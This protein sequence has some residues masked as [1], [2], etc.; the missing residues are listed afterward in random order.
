MKFILCIFILIFSAST[1]Y[2]G[3][4]K[5][6]KRI[7]GKTVVFK[8]DEISVES[9]ENLVA[10]EILNKTETEDLDIPS[11]GKIAKRVK[12]RE[13]IFSGVAVIEPDEIEKTIIPDKQTEESVKKNIDKIIIDKKNDVQDEKNDIKEL[14]KAVEEEKESEDIA[15]EPEKTDKKKLN[16]IQKKEKIPFSGWDE[17]TATLA[18]SQWLRKNETFKNLSKIEQ[19][20][21]TDH[22]LG[23]IFSGE[24]NPSRIKEEIK[25]ETFIKHDFAKKNLKADEIPESQIFEYNPKNFGK[26]PEE[27]KIIVPAPVGKRNI[28][29]MS[30]NFLLWM[31]NALRQKTAEKKKPM[32]W[33]IFP[34]LKNMYGRTV[35]PRMF[36][37]AVILI[38]SRGIHRRK[39]KLY[40]AQGFHGF[41]QLGLEYKKSMVASPQ[42]NL[43]Y[44]VKHLYPCLYKTFVRDE[45]LRR[46][47][48]DVEK[49]AMAA[50]CYNRGRYSR[51]SKLTWENLIRKTLAVPFKTQKYFG[52]HD[53]RIAVKYGIQIK[54][55]CG[56]RLNRDEKRWIMNFMRVKDVNKWCDKK[57]SNMRNALM[58]EGR[59][60]EKYGR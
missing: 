19:E 11:F 22:Y 45:K 25:K 34:E 27:Y 43:N 28:S 38:E 15:E 37:M 5:I 49:L 40:S 47:E 6:S 36:V 44:G 30:P 10:E 12:N 29:F 39:G 56:F 54:A 52:L 46:R 31:E 60:S 2:G 32:D 48:T 57:Y 33:K 26:E 9:M 1:L 58:G 23:I 20:E 41:M 8:G 18:I 24:K 35:T 16:I 55:Y 42:A 21:L 13:L 50:V 7:K 14:E 3:D 4:F 51:A 59:L 17:L 53:N